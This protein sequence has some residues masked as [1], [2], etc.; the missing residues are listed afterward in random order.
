MHKNISNIYIHYFVCS[1]QH[2]NTLNQTHCHKDITTI[3]VYI[4]V[5]I[6]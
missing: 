1:S 2:R 6:I 4:Q 3:I 5:S